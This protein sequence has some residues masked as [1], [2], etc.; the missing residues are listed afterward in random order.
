MAAKRSR[1]VGWLALALLVGLW[2]QLA[3][4]LIETRRVQLSDF[5]AYYSAGQVILAGEPGQLYQSERK[6]FTNLPVVAV[7][8]APLAALEYEDAWSLF[9][10]LQ[11][12]SFGAS[13]GLLLWGVRRHLP[14]LTAGGALLAGAVFVCFAPVL[15]RCLVQ[16]QTTPMMLLWVTGVW[17]LCRA[18]RPRV[19]GLLLG[20]VCLIK[21]PPLIWVGLFALRRRLELAGVAVAV[22]A[23]GVL[24]SWLIFG[25]DV[26]GQYAERVIWSNVG[27]SHA[28]FNNR[29]LDGAFNRMLTDRSLLDW[30][31]RPRPLAG[32]LAVAGAGLG[33]AGL[34]AARGGRKLA[35]PREA[36]RDDDPRT[37]SIELELAL[38]AALM[39]L[40]FPIVWVHY[41]LFLALPMAL[42]PFWW[43]ARKLP[44]PAVAVALLLLG[45]WLAS[46]SEVPGNVEVRE[47][48][49]ELGYRLRHNAQ[50]LGALL[51]VVGLSWPLAELAGRQRE[52]PDAV[53][54]ESGAAQSK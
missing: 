15:R 4:S 5:A 8:V 12:A 9:W 45:T 19:A 49:D 42:L 7:F 43:R 17:L 28:A 6:W 37:G 52:Q 53:R 27:R 40:A 11:V 1:A 18:G 54:S 10:W 26:L 2:A 38:G 44:V 46:G 3:W 34:L 30:D 25:S 32:T 21:I 39:V 13:F 23:A 20:L 22:V 36:P 24:A 51:L 47:R 14:P 16:G 33:L 41:Y 48:V 50:P 31:P 35:W 29:S